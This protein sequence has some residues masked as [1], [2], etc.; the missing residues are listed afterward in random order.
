MNAEEEHIL[1]M[2]LNRL[3]TTV[4]VTGG[5]EPHF[6]INDFFAKLELGFYSF[7]QHDLWGAWYC[8]LSVNISNVLTF[9]LVPTLK[10]LFFP[11]Q[12][13]FPPRV[14]PTM[15]RLILFLKKRIHRSGSKFSLPRPRSPRLSPLLLSL[16]NNH[17]SLTRIYSPS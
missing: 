7:V 4:A 2:N 10:S 1:V 5:K 15:I 6:S 12:T 13:I 14:Q 3:G 9:K 16:S 17:K 8:L 11:S